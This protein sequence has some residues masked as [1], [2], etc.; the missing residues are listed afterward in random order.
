MRRRGVLFV[1]MVLL[2]VVVSIPVALAGDKPNP[3]NT[4]TFTSSRWNELDVRFDLKGLK[5]PSAN[6]SSFGPREFAKDP[7]VSLGWNV[8]RGLRLGA[9]LQTG[10]SDV[11]GVLGF[12]YR[13][14]K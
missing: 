6:G 3:S 1:T 7:S 9:T 14:S 10:G 5:N 4:G 11:R 2:G 13:F 12:E 8:T